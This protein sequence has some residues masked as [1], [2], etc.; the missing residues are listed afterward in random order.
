SFGEYE[1][2]VLPLDSFD[3]DTALIGY[4]YGGILSTAPNI[5]FI[6]TG[7]ESSATSIIYKVFLTKGE[8]VGLGEIKKNEESYN[9]VVYPNPGYGNL[10]LSFTISG[11]EDIELTLIDEY[12]RILS[13]EQIQ[14][15]EPGRHTLKLDIADDVNFRVLYVN[16]EIAGQ[17]ITRKVVI[18]R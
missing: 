17:Q 7:V 15:M 9:L 16:L 8:T 4:I 13:R 10:G 14:H 11:Q 1:N 6:N 18:E 12:G 5:F 3:T 2:G